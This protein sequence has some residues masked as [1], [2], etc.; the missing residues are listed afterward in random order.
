MKEQEDGEPTDATA[1]AARVAVTQC[2]QTV[3]ELLFQAIEHRSL[4][5]KANDAPLHGAIEDH[6]R[7]AQAAT[8]AS[9][10]IEIQR[11]IV[12]RALL[13]SGS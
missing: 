2:D 1:S 8:V 12:S 10:T 11:M 4:E 7:Y 6:W 3:A 5:G 9:G 13:G